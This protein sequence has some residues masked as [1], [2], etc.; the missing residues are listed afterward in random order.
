MDSLFDTINGLPVHA[1]VVHAVVVLLPLSAIGAV[2][3]VAWRSFGRRFG[4]LVVIFSGI[5][6]AASLVSKES[7][8]QLAQRV[9]TPTPHADLGSL[10]PLVAGAFFL[11]VLVYWGFARG[12]PLDRAR[13]TWLVVLGVVV[14][15]AA[16]FTAWWTFRVG[17]SGAE[18]AWGFIIESTNPPK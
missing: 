13:P 4:V 16:V 7:G 17:D 12:I 18:A 2:L 6:A 14:I 5:A 8:E 9:G 11:L 15:I 3:M 10:M 1:L